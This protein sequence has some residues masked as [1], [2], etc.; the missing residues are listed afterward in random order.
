[1]RTVE[2]FGWLA[3][4]ITVLYTCLGIPAQIR[5]NVKQKSTAGLSLTTYILSLMCFSVWVVYGALKTPRDW[6]IIASNFPGAIFIAVILHQ[7]WKYRDGK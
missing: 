7:F 5:Q 6:F 2:I 3:L 1:M 4:I